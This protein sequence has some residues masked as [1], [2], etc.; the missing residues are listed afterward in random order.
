MLQ[1]LD[2]F[3]HMLRSLHGLWSLH[4]LRSLEYVDS[5]MLWSLRDAMIDRWVPICCDSSVASDSVEFA[6]APVET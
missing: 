3:L 4:E 5:Y 2:R 1:L 6:K